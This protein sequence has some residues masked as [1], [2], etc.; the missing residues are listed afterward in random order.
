MNILTNIAFVFPGQGSQSM[1]M[2]SDLA[3]NHREVEETFDLASEVVGK[4]LWEIAQEGPSE[5]LNQT[6]NTQ[7]LMLAADVATWRIWCK[8]TDIRPSWMAGH[9][10]GEYSALVCANAIPFE[11]AVKLVAER[12]RL[13]QEAVPDGIGAMAAILGME[14]HDVVAACKEA[15]GDDVVSAVNFNAPGQVVIAGHAGAVQRAI[16]VAKEH[17]AKKAILLPVSVPSHCALMEPAAEKLD[18]ILQSVEVKT[19]EIPVLHNADVRCHEA[20]EVLCSAL[21]N[22]LFNPVRWT[23]SIRF[24]NDQGVNTFIECGPGKVL[25]GMNKRIVRGVNVFPLIDE[26]SIN[27]T[28]EAL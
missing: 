16:S 26:A 19:P 1:G 23:E 3:T 8:L 2:L 25:S 18:K 9:S 28:L 27:K 11:D 13:M 7:P 15:A 14:N 4:D 10:L 12:A 17:G 22:Q 20:P 6:I 5:V 24:M 21:K